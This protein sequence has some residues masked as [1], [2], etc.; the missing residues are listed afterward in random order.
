MQSKRSQTQRITCHMIHL[1][2]ILS[3]GKS[4]KTDLRLVVP[5]E[6]G[7]EEMGSDCLIST[8]L[9]FGVMKILWN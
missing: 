5:R 9:P 3:T 7:G 1:Y 8:R 2:E 4:I 6:R